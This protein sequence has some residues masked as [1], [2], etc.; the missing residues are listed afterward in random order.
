MSSWMRTLAFV[1]ALAF[2]ASVGAGTRSF[3]IDSAD[4]FAA[5]EL[6]G[7]AVYSTGSVRLGASIE[8]FPMGGVPI[9]RSVAAIGG[10]V[11]IGTGTEGM[12]YRFDGKKATKFA[13]TG[14]LLVSALTV[15]TDRT[16]YAGTIPDGRVFKIDPKTAKVTRYATL[17]DTQF[18]WALEYDSK[19]RRVIAA[20]GPNGKV[21]AID[22][23]GRATV[24]YEGNHGSH[25]MTLARGDRGDLY[26]GTSDKAV[27][28]RI[29]SANRVDIVHDFPGNEITAIDFR[30]GKLAVAMNEFGTPPPG[31]TVG[32]AP[33]PPG[34]SRG[35]PPRAGKGQLWTVD[36]DGRAKKLLARDD[37]HFTSVEWSGDGGVY[38]GTGKGGQILR[39][40]PDASY[41]I[42]AKVEE[43]QI[44]G[45]DLQAKRPVFITGDGAAVYEV[46]PGAPKKAVWV[47]EALDT[48]FRSKWGRLTWRGD[49][50][51]A[52]QTRSGNTEEPGDTWSPWSRKLKRQGQ[53]KSPPG[54]FIQIKAT[55]PSERS[56]NLRA[57]EL[58][59]LPQN[60]PVVI[61]NIQGGPPPSKPSTNDKD[62]SPKPTTLLKLTW[63][64]QN[65]DGDPLRYRL[66]FR[67]EGQSVWRPMFTEDEVLTKNQYVWDTNSIP[68]GYY[69]VRVEASDEQANPRDVAIRT[70]GY[71]EPLRVD[72]HPPVIESLKW[73]RGRIRGR[74]VDAL[75]PVSKIQFSI[76]GGRW[77]EVFP[78]D[79]IFDHPTES[80]EFE[81]DPE[82][83]AGSHIVAV[84]AFDA[85]GNQ[86]N[87]EITVK[88]KR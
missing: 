41:S 38:V 31:P 55:F 82:L 58:F 26:A 8:R 24:L 43:R 69:V 67:E 2:G 35:R 71:S 9:A 44:L 1:G 63:L 79:R 11:F 4:A 7:T 16:L 50:R 86:A 37:T 14:E 57:V 40:E 70:F 53:I 51:F 23:L 47:S 83:P 42:W 59:Y 78:T 45:L 73:R 75:G 62:V 17:P 54:R 13:N 27:V 60:Q 68:D 30:D 19:R 10:D 88:T 29:T 74:V 72:N 25:I 39:V 46:E 48:R 15:G 5:G 52:L 76:N 66:S 20:T 28:L 22:P 80:F 85:S 3:I 32:G 21:F 6:E 64:V 84:R 56:A 33:T 18:V 12:I 61:S 34:P 49:G 65:P 87:R 77:Q 36:A 81:L